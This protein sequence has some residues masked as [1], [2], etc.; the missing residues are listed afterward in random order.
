MNP[1]K[2]LLFYVT[3]GGRV[4]ITDLKYFPTMQRKDNTL[5]LITLEKNETLVGV[6]SV[7]KN[8]IVMIYRKNSEPVQINLNEIKISTRIAKGEKMIKTP[9]GDS[10]IAYKIFS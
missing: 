7:S 10:V 3:S 4:K 2:K 1:K 6:A 8:D 9:K 5:P